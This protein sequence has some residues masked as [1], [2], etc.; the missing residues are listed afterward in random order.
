[1]SCLA[2]MVYVK[3][4]SHICWHSKARREIACAFTMSW[5]PAN[6]V[7]RTTTAKNFCTILRHGSCSA[8]W[9]K[10]MTRAKICIEETI[11]YMKYNTEAIYEQENLLYSPLF[12]CPTSGWIKIWELHGNVYMI[13]ATSSETIRN[14]LCLSDKYF[15]A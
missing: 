10:R 5:C 14:W 3:Y 1:M 11:K 8:Q 6:S 15:L 4:S 2:Q 12:L 7:H 13:P 9:Q